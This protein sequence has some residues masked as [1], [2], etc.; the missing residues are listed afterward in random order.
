MPLAA[1]G[2]DS[3]QPYGRCHSEIVRTTPSTAVC[4]EV[5]EVD[6]LDGVGLSGGN[7]DA[8]VNNQFSQPLPA[9]KDDFSLNL[10]DVLLGILGEGR[11]RTHDPL[12][13][14]E[15]LH[16]PCKHLHQRSH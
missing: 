15:T 8:V 14:T 2:Y 4:L 1:V 7:A 10:G 12:L 5:I 13:G 16:T 6:L 3:A 9:D 11:H